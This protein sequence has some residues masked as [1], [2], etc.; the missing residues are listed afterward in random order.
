MMFMG[1]FWLIVF[2]VLVWLVVRYAGRR[3]GGNG[4]GDAGRT[5]DSA[6]TSVRDRFAR[7]E[8]DEATYRRMLEELRRGH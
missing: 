8:I 2:G 7:G 3:G 1:I 5:G 4:G 6:E